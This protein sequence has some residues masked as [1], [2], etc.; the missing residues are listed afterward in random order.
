MFGFDHSRG[1][2]GLLALGAGAILSAGATPVLAAPSVAV[3]EIK[4]SPAEMDS[5]GMSLFGGSRQQTLLKLVETLDTLAADDDFAGV[6]IRL[7]DPTLGFTQV[8]EI[9]AAIQRVRDAGKRVDLFAEGYGTT[10]LLLGSYADQILMQTGGM[11]SFPGMYME[12]MFLADTLNWIG[13][14]AQLVQVG[15]Y[16][17]AN[18]QMTRTGPSPEWDEN[19]SAL[20]DGLYGNM[21]SK[22]ISGRSLDD[23]GLDEAMQIAWMASG[24]EAIKVGL[25]D[26]EVDLPTLPDFLRTAYGDGV[27]WVNNPYARRERRTDFSN[28]FAILSQLSKPTEVRVDRPTI[29]VLHI[30]GAIVDGDSS[31][32]GLFGGGATVG[33]RTVRNAIERIMK[34]PN[35]KGVVVRVDSPGGSAIASEVMWQGIE[36]LKAEK[37][38]WVSVG[39]MAASGGFYVLSAGDKVYVNP[40]S[41]VGSIGVVGGKISMAGLYD[42]ARVRVVERSRG[43]M[44]GLFGSSEAWNDSEVAA[45]RDRMSQTYD[46]FAARVVAGRP[47]IDLSKTAEGR[48]FVGSEAVGLKMADEVGGL[49]DAINTLAAEV[50]L[51]DFDPVHFPPPPTFEEM[52]E[53]L[54]GGTVQ[55]PVVSSSPFGPLGEMLTGLIG[56]ERYRSVVDSLNGIMLLQREPVLLIN[57]RTII[58]R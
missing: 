38:V 56:E 25:I 54:F 13:L 4:G 19:I 35:I 52:L 45:V 31:S 12:E 15:D 28:P 20:L 14:E 39:S 37:P 34:E 58:V 16:K 17:G 46:L 6:L 41:I 40:S 43:P 2:C 23:A 55:A 50:G 30:N 36:R 3:I 48:L 44:A 10:S 18:E 1:L 27:R 47:G 9:G 26:A 22:I 42:K 8:E 24:E 29:A 11:V 57:P 49:D 21:R 33:S 7:R 53:R 51:V 5:S 32:G